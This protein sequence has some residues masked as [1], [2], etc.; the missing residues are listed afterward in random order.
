MIFIS[1]ILSY[2][3]KN[4]FV[5]TQGSVNASGTRI[6]DTRRIG[7][8]LRYNFGIRKREEQKLPDVEGASQ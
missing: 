5:L 8:N 4:A 3:N 7:L 6:S 2:T 1:I